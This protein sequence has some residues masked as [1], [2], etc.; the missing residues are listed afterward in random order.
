LHQ[1]A[2][3]KDEISDAPRIALAVH[4][5]IYNWLHVKPLAAAHRTDD[6]NSPSWCRFPCT[7]QFLDARPN[8]KVKLRLAESGIRGFLTVIDDDLR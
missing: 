8:L 2:V 4:N 7:L 1:L 5:R 3:T 6:G